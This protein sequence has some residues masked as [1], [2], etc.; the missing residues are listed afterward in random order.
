MNLPLLMPAFLSL[1]DQSLG[2]RILGY[3]SLGYLNLELVNLRFPSP[4]GVQH[5]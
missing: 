1:G 5:R 2:Y 3:Q 4:S